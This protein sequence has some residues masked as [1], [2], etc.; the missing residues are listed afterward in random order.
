M[1]TLHVEECALECS[2]QVLQHRHVPMGPQYC[3]QDLRWGHRSWSLLL[4]VQ[5][6]WGQLGRFVSA[7]RL[8]KVALE[9]HRN[10]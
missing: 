5:V 8:E 10:G 6:I 9:S 1:E 3:L 4:S 7:S 2:D